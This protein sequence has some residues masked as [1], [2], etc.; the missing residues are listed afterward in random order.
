MA[1]PETNETELI[2]QA[3]N[4]SAHAFEEL[5]RRYYTPVVNIAYRICGQSTL[6][7]DMAQETFL[8]AWTN[9]ASFQLSRSLKTWLFRIAV[10]ATLDH[11]RRRSETPIDDEFIQLVVDP[12]L[13]PEAA[14]VNKQQAEHIQR[15]L[16]SLPE[17]A[18]SVLV[19]REYG[20]LSYHEIA[21]VLDVPLGTVMSRLNYARTRLRV[22]LKEQASME[23]VYA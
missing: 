22:L 1:I 5:V 12:G 9:L 13:D 10:N 16:N 18:R 19:L 17:A 23:P 15:L 7:E 4:G 3:Q 8:R 21:A 11:L 2:R 6:A 14:L 20:E